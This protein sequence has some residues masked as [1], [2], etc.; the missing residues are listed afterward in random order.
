M[1]YSSW[2][3]NNSQHELIPRRGRWRQS[4][5]THANCSND[6]FVVCIARR[7]TVSSA[8]SA[9]ARILRRPRRSWYSWSIVRL[10][11]KCNPCGLTECAGRETGLTNSNSRQIVIKYYCIVPF[12]GLS[13][14]S[15]SLLLSA[16]VAFYCK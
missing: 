12:I 11:L 7:Y 13:G 5:E 4:I 15:R 14:L 8:E 9:R 1:S 16:E 6:Q 3:E 2:T 10:Q